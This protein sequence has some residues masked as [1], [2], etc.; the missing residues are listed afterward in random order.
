MGEGEQKNQEKMPMFFMNDLKGRTLF[1]LL[2]KITIRSNTLKLNKK[3]I[4]IGSNNWD[5]EI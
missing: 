3:K 2:L 4:T 5:V 1:N